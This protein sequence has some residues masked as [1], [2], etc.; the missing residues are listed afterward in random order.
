MVDDELLDLGSALFVWYDNSKNSFQYRPISVLSVLDAATRTWGCF[1][2]Y[3]NDDI[4]TISS[5]SSIVLS[6]VSTRNEKMMKNENTKPNHSEKKI[7]ECVLIFLKFC[8]VGSAIALQK[9]GNS[10][11]LP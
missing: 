7:A 2:S 5:I 10:I 9:I 11:F 4:N 8:V 1:Y 6:R 3:Q